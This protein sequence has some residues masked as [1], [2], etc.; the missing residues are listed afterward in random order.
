VSEQAAPRRGADD[1]G[2]LRRGGAPVVLRWGFWVEEHQWGSGKVVVRLT[3]AMQVG[4]GRFAASSSS[5]A[6]MAAVGAMH[7]RA[8]GSTPFVSNGGGGK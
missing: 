2:L 5:P 4:G 6:V 3:R 8:E 7:A 1:D